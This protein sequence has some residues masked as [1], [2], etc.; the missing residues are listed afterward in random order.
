MRDVHMRLRTPGPRAQSATQAQDSSGN[1]V[2][3]H[4]YS[5][6]SGCKL[7][8]RIRSLVVTEIFQ[9]SIQ[10]SLSRGSVKYC[11]LFRIP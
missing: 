6:L 8:M 1:D 11:M 2:T 3:F 7:T 4:F 5:V 10:M 9:M